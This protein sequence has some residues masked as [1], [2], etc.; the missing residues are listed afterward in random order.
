[1]VWRNGINYATAAV[2]ALMLVKLITWTFA[3]KL[4]TSSYDFMIFLF[5][6]E[7]YERMIEGK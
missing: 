4:I 3:H 7:G 6:I 2:D 1:M 5:E